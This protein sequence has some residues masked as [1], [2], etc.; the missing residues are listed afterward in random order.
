M[1]IETPKL[2]TCGLLSTE[3][4]V[5]L[6]CSNNYLHDL[7]G[8]KLVPT[9]SLGT[10]LE[11]TRSFMFDCMICMVTTSKSMQLIQS[12]NVYNCAQRWGCIATAPSKESAFLILAIKPF[13]S[14]SNQ[15][16]LE[17][18]GTPLEKFS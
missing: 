3:T 12:T 1:V 16:K 9:N 15:H 5:N 6:Y 2:A 18:Q 10:R 14:H 11:S 7:T 8:L 17:H 4:G 13:F